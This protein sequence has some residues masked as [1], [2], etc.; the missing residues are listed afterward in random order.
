MFEPSPPRAR[1]SS[2]ASMAGPSRRWTCPTS[3]ARTTA[4][5]T[6]YD[7]T[8]SFEVPAGDHR[9]TVDNVGADWAVVDWYG[10]R[11]KWRDW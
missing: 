7:R 1:A 4:P 9:L 10:F 2:T 3:T 8:W 5:P 6:R 11:G